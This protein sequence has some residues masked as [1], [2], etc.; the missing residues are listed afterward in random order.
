MLAK[1]K[2]P[3]RT[4]LA[5][6]K[7]KMYTCVTCCKIFDTVRQLNGHKSIHREGGRYSASRQ[8]VKTPST[9][10]CV[11]CGKECK[12][13]RNKVNK[14]CSGDCQHEHHWK[15][16]FEQIS[17]G[18]ILDGHMKRYITETRGYKCEECGQDGIHNN[19]PL[20]LQMDHIDGNSDNNSLTNLRLL[21][22][23]CHTQTDTFGNGG[24]GNRYKKITK[25]N[26]YLRAY[27]MGR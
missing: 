16:R 6:P 14:Y 10:S 3:D 13:H 7:F 8:K 25:R 1:H 11:N 21:C 27:K 9:Y 26:K 15:M 12:Y 20:T 2:S 17:N 18:V 24:L 4:R 23:N 19:K 22:P 5:A